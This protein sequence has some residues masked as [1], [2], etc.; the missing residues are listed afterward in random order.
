[1]QNF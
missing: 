1:L